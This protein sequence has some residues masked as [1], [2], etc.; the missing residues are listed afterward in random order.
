MQRMAAAREEERGNA[1]ADLEEK[2]AR[3]DNARR[4][5]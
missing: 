5:H 2:Q 1:V 3:I 4:R